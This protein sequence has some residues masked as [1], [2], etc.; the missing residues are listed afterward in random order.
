MMKYIFLI[1]STICLM[2][3]DNNQTLNIK[4]DSNQTVINRANLFT[5]NIK[6]N[7]YVEFSI[8]LGNPKK[9][10]LK[11]KGNF[12]I[13]DIFGNIMNETNATFSIQPRKAQT[14]INRSLKVKVSKDT[15]AYIQANLG[16]V[17]SR[18]KYFIIHK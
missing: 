15:K 17:I 16:G 11:I 8:T 2:A 18:S 13:I 5:S 9:E 6:N 3:V 1:L 12:Q 7:E 10:I 14:Y 4:D